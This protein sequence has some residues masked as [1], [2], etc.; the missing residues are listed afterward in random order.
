MNAL[1]LLA[2]TALTAAPDI[3]FALVERTGAKTAR[4][5]LMEADPRLQAV[6][7]DEAGL[8]QEQIDAAKAS[9]YERPV[10]L[11]L[12][13]RRVTKGK[14]SELHS[15]FSPFGPC[16]VIAETEFS[17]PIPLSSSNDVLWASTRQQDSTPRRPVPPGAAELARRALPEP[18]AS[19]CVERTVEITRATR[20]G[21]YV[22]LSCPVEGKPVLAVVYLPA[23]GAAQV[24]LNQVSEGAPLRLL[25]VLNP[26]DHKD[27]ILVFAR[28]VEQ[29]R[30]YELWAMEEGT[31]KRQGVEEE[32]EVEEETQVAG[33]D[34]T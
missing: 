32:E 24:L 15:G 11:Y 26:L 12:G 30:R 13:P 2:L 16:A 18:L 5:V 17:A 8:G 31:L 4:L 20:A 29:G 22:Q 25:E 23:D 34:G 3:G 6:C 28:E 1:A 9:L 33:N 7:F 27:H 14:V 21:T 19:A 10:W